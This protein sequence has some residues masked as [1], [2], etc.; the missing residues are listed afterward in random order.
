M[1]ATTTMLAMTPLA[2]G[3]GEGSE[4]QA[5]MARAI[6]GGLFS[7]TFITLIVV[8]TVYSLITR[9]HLYPDE[10]LDSASEAHASGTALP[11]E[12]T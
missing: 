9:K 12:T 7:S 2:L 8:P 1:T 3:L 4:A 6:V 5:P 10:A 11:K